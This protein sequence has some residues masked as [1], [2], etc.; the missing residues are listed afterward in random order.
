MQPTNPGQ[1]SGTLIDSTGRRYAIRAERLVSEES[2]SEE[3]AANDAPADAASTPQWSRV[4]ARNR[5]MPDADS[6]ATRRRHRND[7]G[8]ALYP[9]NYPLGSF[10]RAALPEQ[11]AASYSRT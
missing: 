3:E 10:G 11:P 6:G 8:H 4:L 1:A 5:A 7:D 2:T 9:V